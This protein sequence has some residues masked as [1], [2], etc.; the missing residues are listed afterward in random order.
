MPNTPSNAIA[1]RFFIQDIFFF[2]VELNAKYALINN[3]GFFFAVYY[4]E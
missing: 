3:P 4:I 1:Y 2:V